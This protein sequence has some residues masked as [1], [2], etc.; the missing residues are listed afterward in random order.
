MDAEKA[1]DRHSIAPFRRISVADVLT[2]PEPPHRFIWDGRIPANA[3]TLL[4][5][6]GGTGKSGLALQMAIHFA[7]GRPF[8]GCCVWQSKTLF[9]SAEDAHPVIRNRLGAICQNNDLDPEFL[10]TRLECLDATEAAILWDEDRKLKKA[11]GTKSY[12]ALESFIRDHDIECLIVDNASDTFGGDPINRGQVT[13]YVRGLVRLVSERAG[14][15]VLL[16]HV[17]KSTA[18]N[19]SGNSEGYADSAAWNNAARSRLFLSANDDGRLTLEHQKCNYGPLQ[20]PLRLEMMEGG[21]MCLAPSIDDDGDEANAKR[22]A[23]ICGLLRLTSSYAALGQFVSPN[24]NA[25]NNAGNIFKADPAFL[26]LGISKDDTRRLYMEMESRGLIGRE[27]YTTSARN[28]ADRYALTAKG[29]SFAED[30]HGQ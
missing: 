14:T 28:Q 20:K 29:E 17:A 26:R 16:G 7:L 10:A 11:A 15:V 24:L 8:L 13:S 1:T 19:P 12:G 21:G 2:N 30:W 18:R 4:S 3:L 25:R 22:E 27:S 5:G 23:I 6:H 9:F